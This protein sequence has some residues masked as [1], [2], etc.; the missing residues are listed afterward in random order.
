MRG[1]LGRRQS[2]TRRATG[3]R[4]PPMTTL[5]S[6]GSTET[7]GVYQAAVRVLLCGM[8]MKMRAKWAAIV[9]WR[10]YQ[11]PMRAGELTRMSATSPRTQVTPS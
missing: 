9:A 4:V 8:R 6:A 7:S 1:V 3:T 5:R 10:N 2:S 11:E